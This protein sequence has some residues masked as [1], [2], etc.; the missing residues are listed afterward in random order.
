MADCT[1]FGIAIFSEFVFPENYEFKEALFV[2]DNVST[3]QIYIKLA[4]LES[5]SDGRYKIAFSI[6]W[7]PLD[8]NIVMTSHFTSEALEDFKSNETLK[9]NIPI[10]FRHLTLEMKELQCRLGIGQTPLLVSSD[11]IESI[12]GKLKS[13][14]G[15]SSLGELNRMT[16]L[17]PALCGQVTPDSIETALKQTTHTD[18][19]AAENNVIPTTLLQQR[20]RLL[21]QAK[22]KMVVPEA[23]PRQMAG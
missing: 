6:K 16:L 17:M 21:R 3:Q 5:L 14:L 18:L 13:T 20:R 22:Q 23:L 7:N 12:L 4:R 19:L 11:A 2:I 8:I 15:R 10:L 9:Q 1:S